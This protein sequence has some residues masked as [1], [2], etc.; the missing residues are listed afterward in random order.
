MLAK[1]GESVNARDSEALAGRAACS[2]QHSKSL[3]GTEIW[4]VGIFLVARK[5]AR[6]LKPVC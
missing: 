2:Q 6:A 1:E 4:H 5:A 3:H